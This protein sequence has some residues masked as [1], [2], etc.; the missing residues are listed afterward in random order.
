M[1]SNKPRRW[2]KPSGRGRAEGTF[3]RRGGLLVPVLYVSYRSLPGVKLLGRNLDEGYLFL[4][5][6]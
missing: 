3:W 2:G 5:V 1:L 4:V 6:R